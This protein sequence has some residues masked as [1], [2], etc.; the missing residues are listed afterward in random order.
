MRDVSDHLTD[1]LEFHGIG[2]E[3]NVIIEEH[4]WIDIPRFAREVV[5]QRTQSLLKPWNFRENVSVAQNS[6][7][8][9]L[10]QFDDF[11]EWRGGRGIFPEEDRET[12]GDGN[13]IFEFDRHYSVTQKRRSKKK[14]RGTVGLMNAVLQKVRN[15][16]KMSSGEKDDLLSILS[17]YN[18]PENLNKARRY[19]NMYLD[20]RTRQNFPARN[21]LDANIAGAAQQAVEPSVNVRTNEENGLL[22]KKINN[23][24]KDYPNA[25]DQAVEN[26]ALS[27]IRKSVGNNRGE[28]R[29]RLRNM[30]D[31]TK[32]KALQIYH[33]MR[34]ENN[35]KE[36]IDGVENIPTNIKFH[37]SS[38]EKD[39]RSI[40]NVLKELNTFKPRAPRY[41]QVRLEEQR[42]RN[43]YISRQRR[44]GLLDARTI[45]AKIIKIPGDG[46]C[47]FTA[48]SQGMNAYKRLDTI[49]STGASV[50]KKIVDYEHRLG[51][52]K[53]FGI[54]SG[55]KILMAESNPPHWV[56]MSKPGVYGGHQEIIAFQELYK[57][58]VLI[59]EHR[60]N[61]VFVKRHSY[62]HIVNNK[63][64]GPP[65]AL[66]YDEGRQHYDLLTDIRVI[67]RLR[68]TPQQSPQAL[69]QQ[70]IL[71]ALPSPL[72]S[73]FGQT[74]QPPRV[75]SSPSN[76]SYG[77]SGS[78]SIII[79]AL[80]CVSS[81][82]R[83]AVNR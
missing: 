11:W 30:N 15:H 39:A 71:Q 25:S 81:I 47:L 43:T 9:D 56:Q 52:K 8:F 76:A 38:R 79:G 40:A 17:T 62:E 7:Q 23:V 1:E 55:I 74:S 12:H 10:D 82:V 48:L 57:Y 37:T 58:P 31:A 44:L 65:I 69:P 66:L 80:C 2:Q 72:S 42:Q 33:G 34:G 78:V 60:G 4:W 5:L 26:R 20:G 64:N 16:N 28:F 63:I 13:V 22:K 6:S 29:G 77:G 41:A 50:R 14:R 3:G 70:G 68:G 19:L 24:R 35:Y 73:G 18:G 21:R 67:D 59:F 45:T 53:N 36:M 83:M 54:G 46:N 75:F 32:R 49:P 51:R 61:N 27:I